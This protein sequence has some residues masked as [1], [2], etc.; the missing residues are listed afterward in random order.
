MSAPAP[1]AS[2]L[3]AGVPRRPALPA[4]PASA[5]ARWR[6]RLLGM[7]FEDLLAERRGFRVS[8]PAAAVHQAHIAASFWVGYHAT[9]ADPRPEPVGRA[10]EGL[11]R[12]W[13]GFAC[14][15]VGMALT[16]LDALAPWGGRRLAA[17]LAGPAAAHRY[18]L[19]LGVGFALARVPWPRRRV[20]ADLDPLCR[21]LVFDG[22]GFHH[23]FLGGAGSSR[24]RRVRSRLS[25]YARRVFDQGLG[26]SVWFVH[27]MDAEAAGRAIEGFPEERR[28][29][30][31]SGLGLAAAYG[32]GA[33][34]PALLELA[35]RSGPWRADLLQG[36]A[37]AATARV[38]GDDLAA[39]TD[40]ACRTLCGTGAAELT[41]LCQEAARDLPDD[42][43]RL[44]AALPSWEA[45]RR[46]VRSALDPGG[47]AP[48]NS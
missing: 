22:C 4:P 19:Y 33:P 45:W 30:L 24:A 36:V 16:L 1:P 14:E 47:A 9:L 21:W 28:G 42:G 46:R 35:S 20:L 48:G 43:G 41:A 6:L 39:H 7:P 23:G 37:F 12:G 34:P 17:L 10:I 25:G 11:E 13:R 44:D 3:A 15:G 29:D 40:E 8:R 5:L 31:W 26:R 32:G 18:L 2:G 38:E 27:G